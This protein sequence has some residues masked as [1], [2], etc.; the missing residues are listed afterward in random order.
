MR[1]LIVNAVCGTGSTGRIVSGLWNYLTTRG[2]TARI[3]FGVG[4]A[5][6]VKQSDLIRI[7]DKTGYYIHNALSR[8]TDRAGFYSIKQTKEFIK[9]VEDYAPDIVYMHNLHGYYINIDLWLR[10]LASSKIPVILTLHDCWLFTGHC[11]YFII[12]GCDRWKTS[13]YNCP[14]KR[15]YPQSLAFDQSRRNYYQKRELLSALP[16]LTITTP[17][18]WL[19]DLARK[20]FLNIHP[21]VTLANGIDTSVFTPTTSDLKALYGIEGKRMVLAVANVWDRRKGLNDVYELA[22]KHPEYAYVIVG[23]TDD[24]IK[25]SPRGVI[26]I[27]RTNSITELVKIYTA[28]DVFINPTY[29]DNFPLV[30]LEALSCGTPVITYKTGGASEMVNEASG[31]VTRVGDVDELAKSIDH[32]CELRRDYIVQHGRTY[33]QSIMFNKY[34][35]TYNAARK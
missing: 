5:R 6:G 1:A 8:I 4:E 10:W 32:A 13:C 34:L 27:K 9:K 26:P 28:A 33:D 20:S 25:E 35:E 16:K 18:H 19:S 22:R 24:Q 29:E 3:A 11:T 23:L 30:N 15:E 7:N 14:Q 12:C 2:H 21:I 17:S 31:V